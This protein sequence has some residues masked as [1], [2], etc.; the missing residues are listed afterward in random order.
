GAPG[1][2]LSLETIPGD[3]DISIYITATNLNGISSIHTVGGDVSIRAPGI[4]DMTGFQIQSIGGTLQI[5]D[6]QQLVN[7]NG[8]TPALTSVNTLSIFANEN[9]ESLS[10]LENL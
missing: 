5:R 4:T 3:M 2:N 1:M 6:C 10:A 9:L 7:F 8:M